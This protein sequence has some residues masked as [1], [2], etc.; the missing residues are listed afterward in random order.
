MILVGK[1]TREEEVIPKEVQSMLKSFK[2]IMPDQLPQRP[3]FQ[4]S[5]DHLIELLPGV[6]PPTKGPYC[7]APLELTKL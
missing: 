6:K 7:M 3:L 5:V 2:D 1:E 4:R